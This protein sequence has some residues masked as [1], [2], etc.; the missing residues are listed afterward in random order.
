MNG[1]SSGRRHREAQVNVQGLERRLVHVLEDVRLNDTD[2][3]LKAKNGD[4]GQHEEDEVD[5]AVQPIVAAPKG[6]EGAE[7][8]KGHGCDRDLQDEDDIRASQQ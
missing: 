3:G 4:T 2:D 7:E 5:A 1:I 6:D 8:K